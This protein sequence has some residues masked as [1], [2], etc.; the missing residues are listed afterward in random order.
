MS[1]FSL[2]DHISMEITILQ[3]DLTCP[4]PGTYAR[5]ELC[6]SLI[7]GCVE[8]DAVMP[9]RFTDV[10]TLSHHIAPMSKSMTQQHSRNKH[11]CTMNQEL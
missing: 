6:T 9:V 10:K 3:F 5:F 8:L 7:N 4:P 2:L 11:E 1:R